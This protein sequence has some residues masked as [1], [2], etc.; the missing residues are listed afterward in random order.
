[1]ESTFFAAQ[2][3]VAGEQRLQAKVL[4]MLPDGA[5][6]SHVALETACQKISDMQSTEIF[7][8]CNIAAQGS[9]KSCAEM[10]GQMMSGYRPTT[11]SSTPFLAKVRTRLQFFC[12][13]PDAANPPNW[14][15]GH[16]AVRQLFDAASGKT[17]S[18]TMEELEP[19]QVYGWLLDAD[20]QEKVT[21][22]VT[23]ALARL[24]GECDKK[25][26][27]VKHAKAK[28]KGLKGSSA[29][30]SSRKLVRERSDVDAAL[31]MFK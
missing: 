14:L 8:F 27:D 4:D 17:D 16:A 10:M 23:A 5:E 24:E 7:L 31:S 22:M 28:A 29:S 3:G 25:G 18:I 12:R 1:M 21:D 19:L 9:I 2:V 11:T 30:S 20:Q 26:D 6:G 13:V 15:S